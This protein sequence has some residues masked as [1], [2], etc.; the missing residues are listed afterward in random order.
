MGR[1]AKTATANYAPPVQ[2]VIL[3]PELALTTL[4]SSKEILTAT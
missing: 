3:A 2:P 4:P 1:N